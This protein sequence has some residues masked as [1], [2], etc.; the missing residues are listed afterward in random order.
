[1][2][3]FCTMEYD[4]EITGPEAISRMRN[5]KLL[6]DA[7]FGIKFITCD[8]NRDKPHEFRIYHQCRLRPALHSEK[9]KIDS[10]HYLYFVDLEN[11]EN[12]QCFRILIRAVCLPPEYKWYK[13]KWFDE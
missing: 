1:M 4:K 7:T 3:F 9:Q 12:R 8:L 13:I 2:G 5:L 6:P 10:D 11:K